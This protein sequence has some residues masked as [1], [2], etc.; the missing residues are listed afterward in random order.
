MARFRLCWTRL[1][2]RWRLAGV[3]HL[4][5]AGVSE[6]VTLVTCE[7]LDVTSCTSVGGRRFSDSQWLLEYRVVTTH[8][9]I[10]D[11]MVV[12]VFVLQARLRGIGLHQ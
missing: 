3:D 7:C 11:V 10:T 9:H 6:T 12:C 1:D 2:G 5:T 8:H 4:P